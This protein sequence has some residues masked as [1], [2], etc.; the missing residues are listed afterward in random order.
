[1]NTPLLRYHLTLVLVCLS[2]LANSPTL[3]YL[4][5]SLTLKDQQKNQIIE[6]KNSSS[7]NFES[8]LTVGRKFA[9]SQLMPIDVGQIPKI[10]EKTRSKLLKNFDLLKSTQNSSDLTESLGIS[11]KQAEQVFSSIKP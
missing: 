3:D 4:I 7:L 5:F 2:L 9:L 11:K 1:M 10:N 8:A 6:Q